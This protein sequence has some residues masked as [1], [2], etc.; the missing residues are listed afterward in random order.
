MEAENR[1]RRR[2]VLTLASGGA[3]QPFRYSVGRFGSRFF[4]ELRD[5]KRF[6]GVRCPGCRMF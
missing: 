4:T 3:F 1:I 5:S 2:D 6:W